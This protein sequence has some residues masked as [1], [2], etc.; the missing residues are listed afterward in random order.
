MTLKVVALAGATADALR[1][2]EGGWHMLTSS[3]SER[4]AAFRA[5]SDTADFVAAHALLRVAAAEV[6][7]RDTSDISIVQRC[8]ACGGAHG[9]PLMLD[10]PE[11]GLS[12]SHTRGYVAVIAGMSGVGIDVER[13]SEAGP[14]VPENVFTSNE[15]ALLRD[16]GE[17]DRLS[18]RLWVRKE[19]LMKA[20]GLSPDD[21]GGIDVSGVDGGFLGDWH[22][23]E[24]D[25]AEVFTP[26]T[27]LARYPFEV[28]ELG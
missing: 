19:A 12:L 21:L 9:Q 26:G 2:T 24:W 27:A 23:A 18:L 15:V 8:A 17:P 11:V 4:A 16:S 3:E 6:L 1:L 25:G 7:G 13:Q 10:S 5:P 14:A 22:V 28:R 20:A